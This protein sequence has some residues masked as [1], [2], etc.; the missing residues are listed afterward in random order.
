LPPFHGRITFESV[1][2]RYPETS[3]G[4]VLNDV[5]LT[6][7]AGEV[8]ALVG[9][10]GAGKTTFANLVPRFIDVTSGR[11]L[12]DG[13]DIRDV[14]LASLRRQIGIVAQETFLFN[15]TVAENIRYGRPDALMDEVQEAARNA[16]AEEFILA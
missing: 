4:C 12:V 1:S 15:T 14:Q 3:N 2:F 7:H 10:S 6:V 13:H 16:M 11:I 9:P 5:N 8:A